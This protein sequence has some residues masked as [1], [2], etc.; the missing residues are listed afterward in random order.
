MIKK[1]AEIFGFLFLRDGATMSRFP[2][3]I[4]LDSVKNTPVAVLE[5]FDCQG[6]LANGKKW[7]IYL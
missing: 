7:N 6:H 3:L 2:L 1:E 5:I 4:I